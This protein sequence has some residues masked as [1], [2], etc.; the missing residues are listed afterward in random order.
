MTPHVSIV[1]PAWN[2]AHYI[3][4]TVASVATQLSPDDQYIV[5]DDGSSDG[6]IALLEELRLEYGFTLIRQERGG[7][8]AA[9]NAGLAAAAND[10]VCVVN[11]DDPILDGL[12]DRMKEV[13]WEQPD[14]AAAYPDWLMID[15]KGVVVR[16]VRT[17][18]YS[19]RTMLAEHFCIPGPG[20]FF[21]RDA[22]HGELWRDARAEGL[23]DFDFWIRFGRNG[24]LVRR[25]PQ[26][27]ATW[28]S[29]GS[30]TTATI[31]GDKLARA[32][33]D[34]VTRFFGRVD[35]SPEV[36]VMKAQA[37]SAA[38]YQAALLGL[39]H[40][41]I[42]CLRYAVASFRHMPVWPAGVQATQRRSLPHL[43]YAILQPISGRLH[44]LI[45]PLLPPRYRRSRVLSQ[46]FGL[47]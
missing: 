42:P 16:T 31:D 20:A 37:S 39:R 25:L 33:I 43:A 2:A 35:L 6:S 32:K 38:Y 23:S 46:T 47:E 26:V 14:L 45:D 15:E 10:L 11:A 17:V 21:R 13:F 8:I 34:L 40:S 19:Y 44:G 28:R 9:V 41:G 4:E 22:F 12:V 7:E 27:L 29:H 30:G 18:P 24:A 36:R 3:R 1:T 5:V